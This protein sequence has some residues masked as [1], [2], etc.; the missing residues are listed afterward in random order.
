MAITLGDTTITGLGVGGLPNGVV[1][2][3]DIAESAITK[4]KMGFAGAV[5]QAGN[6]PNPIAQST[7]VDTTTMTTLYTLSLTPSKTNTRFL[8]YMNWMIYVSTGGNYAS[9]FRI[10]AN[11]STVLNS[12]TD[13][14]NPYFTGASGF[15]LMHRGAGMR[16]HD[17]GTTSAQSYAF[18]FAKS[19]AD[20][21]AMDFN[22]NSQYN[23][24]IL[25]MEVQI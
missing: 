20:R 4:A 14:H 1:N 23:S 11:G 18:Q 2:A 16:S 12:A 13:S 8:F 21:A 6:V 15:A 22:H 3:D 9:D 19:S 24:S 25:W 10:L 7:V 5:L 17:P